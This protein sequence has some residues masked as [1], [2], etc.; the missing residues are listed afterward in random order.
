MV[1]QK[2]LLGAT[3]VLVLVL[4]VVQWAAAVTS[5]EAPFK[6]SSATAVGSPDAPAGGRPASRQSLT[7]SSPYALEPLSISCGATGVNVPE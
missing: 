4:L 1:N 2:R 6:E 3:V 5:A 7:G